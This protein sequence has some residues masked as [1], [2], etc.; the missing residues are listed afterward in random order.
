MTRLIHSSCIGLRERPAPKVT[1]AVVVRISAMLQANRKWI[2]LRVLR[3]C[4]PEEAKSSH[5]AAV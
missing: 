3:V 4:C 5:G 2:E 1:V